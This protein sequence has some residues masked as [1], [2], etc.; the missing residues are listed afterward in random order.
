M[1][2]EAAFFS[3]LLSAAYPETDPGVDLWLKKIENSEHQLKLKNRVLGNPGYSGRI[4]IRENLKRGIAVEGNEKRRVILRSLLAFALIHSERGEVDHEAGCVE[5]SRLISQLL[6]AKR[7]DL[8]VTA[9]DVFLRGCVSSGKRRRAKAPESFG[10]LCLVILKQSLI[11]SAPAPNPKILGRAIRDTSQSNDAEKLITDFIQENSEKLEIAVLAGTILLECGSNGKAE[12]ILK[13]CLNTA[14][15]DSG[16]RAYA[17]AGLVRVHS[18]LRQYEKAIQMQKEL[19]R[20]TGGREGYSELAQLMVEG[21]EVRRGTVPKEHLAAVFE[22]GLSGNPC[23]EEL[24]Q[25]CSWFYEWKE[26]AKVIEIARRAMKT[27]PVHISKKQHQY[28]AEVMLGKALHAI[29]E[30]DDAKKYLR[31]ALRH[32]P[33]RTPSNMQ[34][35]WMVRELLIEFGLSLPP[36]FPPIETDLK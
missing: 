11:G 29:G 3:V 13:K 8:Y 17:L 19:I 18:Q 27:R 26:Y 24:L 36:G 33:E 32:Y 20:I 16:Q 7:F 23:G 22:E 30:K 31:R 25:T 14:D 2:A 5:Y 12:E 4:N 15:D 34:K 35:I 6:S 9:R 28:E 1:I 21:A 10:K